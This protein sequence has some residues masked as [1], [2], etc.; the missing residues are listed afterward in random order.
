MKKNDIKALDKLNVETLREKLRE[1][2]KEVFRAYNA[3]FQGT[4]KDAHA[5]SKVKKDIAR[6]LTVLRK[7][8]LGL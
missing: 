4:T 8:E 1:L 7:K 6:V 2:K 5:V 3:R